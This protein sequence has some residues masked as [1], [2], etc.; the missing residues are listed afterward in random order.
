MWLA[1]PLTRTAT[2]QRLVGGT[3][4]PHW[5]EVGKGAFLSVQSNA[6]ASR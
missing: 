5:G 4:S 1:G 3:T 2:R 6:V